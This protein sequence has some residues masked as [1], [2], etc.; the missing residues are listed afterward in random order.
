MQSKH[1]S[2]L[3]RPATAAAIAA[4]TSPGLHVLE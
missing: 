4:A 2:S 3:R 1:L